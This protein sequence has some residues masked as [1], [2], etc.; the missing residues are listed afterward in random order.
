MTSKFIVNTPASDLKLLTIEE[1]RG[2]CSISG[3]GKD[4]DLIALEKRV[5]LRLAR[6]CKVRQDDTTPPTFRKETI[7]ETFHYY[8]NFGRIWSWNNIDLDLPNR[9][10]RSNAICLSRKFVTVVNS[11]TLG[12][13]ELTEDTDFEVQKTSGMIKRLYGSNINTVDL[14]SNDL[15]V[16]Y[17]CGFDTVPDDLKLAAEQLIRNYYFQNTRDS[18]V[19]EIEIPGVIRRVYTSG[20][21]SGSEPDI[22]QDILDILSPYMSYPQG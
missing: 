15:I 4:S 22:S 5:A 12:G 19:R 13:T 20:S 7:I 2:A 21:G 8:T 3:N 6:V 17:D 10:N 16:N 11:L 14:T 18:A 1:M 9:I